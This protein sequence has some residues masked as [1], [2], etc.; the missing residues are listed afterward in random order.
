M[1]P[2]LEFEGFRY[3]IDVGA[4]RIDGSYPGIQLTF[5]NSHVVGQIPQISLVQRGH[6][7]IS[8]L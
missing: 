7:F 5:E 2:P 4:I 6:K 1:M 3:G 8:L